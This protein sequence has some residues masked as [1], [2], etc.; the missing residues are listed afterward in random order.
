LFLVFLWEIGQWD[1]KWEDVKK[2]TTWRP[3]IWLGREE[4][5]M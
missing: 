3:Q 5:E 4:R 2:E 1:G